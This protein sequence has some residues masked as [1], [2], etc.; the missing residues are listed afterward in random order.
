MSQNIAH[1][2][3]VNEKDK[4]QELEL[5]LRIE[6][7]HMIQRGRSLGEIFKIHF[8]WEVKKMNT[9][10]DNACIH[11]TNRHKKLRKSLGEQ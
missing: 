9:R 5:L 8:L 6:I 4:F 7:C 3:T 1:V 2:I 11:L 10:Q